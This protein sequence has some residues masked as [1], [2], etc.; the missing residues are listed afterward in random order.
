MIRLEVGL[1]AFGSAAV[2]AARRGSRLRGAGA[3][4]AP[5]AALMLLFDH[6][7]EQRA[8]TYLAWLRSL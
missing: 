3:G 2:L 5:Q 1:L 4:L 6:L 8:E 7:A